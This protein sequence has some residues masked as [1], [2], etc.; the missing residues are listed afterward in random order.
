MKP[1]RRLLFLAPLVILAFSFLGG[2][3]APG[4]A[5]V[6]AASS[7]D[8]IRA[9]V[10]TFTK[11]YSLV[12]QNFAEPLD[13]DKAIY[14]GAIPG[15]LRTLDPHSSFFDPR[16]FQ[17]LREDQRGQYFGV[18]MKVGARN[19]MTIVMEI[20]TGAPA[21]KAGIRPGDILVAVSDKSTEGLSTSDVADLLKGP[22]G[23]TVKVSVMRQG[24][25][26]PL[27][28]EVTRDA[29]SR[30]SV[31][32]AFLVR[33]GIA[34]MQILQFNETTSREMDDNLKRLGEQNL[35][36]LI[37]D[38]RNNPGGLLN[39]G[40]AV[41]DHYLR[42]GQVIVSHRGRSSAEK[43]YTAHEGGAGRDYPIVV[44]VNRYS[45]SAA[46]IVAGALQDHDRA[47]VLGDNTFG[48][49]LVQTVYPLSENTGL[50]LTTAKYY[51]PSGRLIQ[52]DYS[53]MSFFDYYYRKNTDT[54]NT[55][56]VKMT[57]SGRTVYGGGG[58][59]PDEKYALP[60]LN[61]FQID[62]LQESAFFTFT[63]K[64]FGTNNS[65]LPKN[66]EPDAAVDSEFHRFLTDSKIAFTEADYTQ[67]REWMRTQLKREMYAYAFSID[68]ANRVAV[69]TDPEVGKAADAMPKARA[70]LDTARKLLAQRSA[71]PT[72]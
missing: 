15:M 53:S 12:E 44:L 8:D 28:F 31:P 33:P 72:N 43:Q 71:K 21:Y 58:I 42:K 29:I 68:D 45:A 57:D 40:V 30:K 49:G 20:F 37:L 48:K 5:G 52:R 22:R 63:A 11:V 32:D 50:A 70:L 23:T 19:N 69:E 7:E 34:Y 3:Y 62:L 18:G 51:T 6:S 13:A 4:V 47:W 2:V 67:N 54:Q 17:L 1:T 66:W 56:D 38:L 61:R 25:S 36:G 14:K 41:A 26:D 64:Y 55:Q 59:A 27:V 35:K 46:E 65:K 24:H 39:E 60:K 10:S 9:S 16:D